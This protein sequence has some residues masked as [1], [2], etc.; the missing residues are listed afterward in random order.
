MT[1]AT[2]VGLRGGPLPGI[3]RLCLN[4]LVSIPCPGCQQPCHNHRASEGR[5]RVK[6]SKPNSDGL[7]PYDECFELLFPLL[8]HMAERVLGSAADAEDVVVDVMAVGW[9]KHGRFAANGQG[10]EGYRKYLCTVCRRSAIRA[11]KRR[12]SRGEITEPAARGPVDRPTDPDRALDVRKALAV[13][14]EEEYLALTLHAVYDMTLDEI[15][16]RLGHS[17]PTVHRRIKKAKEK[18]RE[19]IDLNPDCGVTGP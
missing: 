4:N 17:A 3:L 10:L 15:G 7:P 11:A 2:G 8:F 13:L 16:E 18:L 6:M 12:K 5:K 19:V 14:D 9:Q 1:L